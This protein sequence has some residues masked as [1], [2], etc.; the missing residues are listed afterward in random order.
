[1]PLTSKI[2]VLFALIPGLNLAQTS[3]SLVS[4]LNPSNYGESVT[5]TATVTCTTGTPSATVTFADGAVQLGSPVSLTAGSAALSTPALIAGSHVITAQYAGDVNCPAV[6][7]PSLTQ[8]VNPAAGALDLQAS[9]F[10]TL[11]LLTP[12][13]FTSQSESVPAGTLLSG[14]RFWEF[15]IVNS[16]T[17][18]SF[19]TPSLAI[20]TTITS[21]SGT[22]GA[23]VYSLVSGPSNFTLGTPYNNS[24][25]PTT[26]SSTSLPPNTG[27]EGIWF[28]NDILGTGTPGFDST[29]SVDT[30]MIPP[31]GGY[32]NVT[33]TIT[34][35]DARYSNPALQFT[36]MRAFM[37]G[38][39][40][41]MSGP[42][43]PAQSNCSPNFGA[44]WIL[45][46]DSLHPS[47]TVG[48]TYTFSAQLLVSNPGSTPLEYKP[49]VTVEMDTA[50]PQT[51]A[52]TAN[53]VTI[54]D[55]YLGSVTY[56]VGSGLPLW[57]Y[58]PVQNFYQVAYPAVDGTSVAVT[59][60]ANPSSPG[61]PVTFSATV[62]NVSAP[63][64]SIFGTVQFYDG[65]ALLGTGVKNGPA[66]QLTTSSLSAGAHN[67]TAVLLPAWPGGAPM[68]ADTVNDAWAG[69]TSPALSQQVG[70]PTTI[71]L[72]SSMNPAA[73]G[74]AVAFT[75]MVAG[76]GPAPTGTVVFTI[77]SSAGATTLSAT[78]S[79]GQ[80]TTGGLNLLPGSY[81][82][83]AT[84]SGD[85][86]NDASSG[87]PL[88]ES[89]GPAVLT[90]S[91]TALN[92]IY[93]G[94]NRATISKCT[95]TGVVGSD[96]VSCLAGAATFSSANAGTNLAVTATGITLSGAAAGDYQLSATTAV[97]T[98]N[99]TPAAATITLGSL[100]L[101]YNGKAL[102]VSATVTPAICG[103]ASVTYAGSA[104][105]PVNP[106]SYAVAASLANTSC[107]G[108]NA[109]GT[110]IVYAYLTSG[111]F[112]I[113]DISAAKGGTQ[114]FW[115]A[116]WAKSNQLSRGNPPANFKGF[117][118]QTGTNPPQCGGLW[119]GNPGNSSNPP[120]SIPAYMAVIVATT[121]NQ[122]GSSINGDISQIVI[123]KTNAGYAND[124]GHTGTG[125]IVAQL[126][127]GGACQ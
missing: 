106:G 91:V 19:P 76:S 59:S 17:S 35:Q 12:P 98:A 109:S 61:Q 9:L 69:S 16:Y 121:A 108:P 15:G 119:S 6:T 49:Q 77:K 14:P 87:G 45:G 110:L 10:D 40:R 89:V 113:G 103:P 116:Q 104:T 60:N 43:N 18:V 46:G 100:L 39:C 57:N 88:S 38:D 112:V 81:T 11:L 58:G 33:V 5:F 34:P 28:G 120:A 8:L 21:Q 13:S 75:A 90:A 105:A 4:S 26:F 50:Y 41:S 99:I 52:S 44:S 25:F 1:M 85:A 66:Y 3:V 93:D 117:A 47:P 56:S 97:T 118:D 7:S 71:S 92:K 29:R 79:G 107:T 73:Y 78:I 122:Y 72:T 74:Q 83:T 32:Q 94:T 22:I 114:T 30:L 42:P 102:P 96:S 67:I 123:V 80:A 24:V 53:S 62:S 23:Q 36:R 54:A 2:C 115:G 55:P 127:S 126:C 20:D 95:L 84:Y 37:Q 27:F 51:A 124:P 31:G 86:N 101:A 70:F 48:T 64:S 65:A 125:T 68:A 111:S 82:V 63:S